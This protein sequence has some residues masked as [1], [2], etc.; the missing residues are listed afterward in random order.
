MASLRAGVNAIATRWSSIASGV[1]PGSF[2]RQTAAPHEHRV[3]GTSL[4]PSASALEFR[5]AGSMHIRSN[6]AAP[7]GS[8]QF[9][10]T[11]KRR[12]I[13]IWPIAVQALSCVYVAPCWTA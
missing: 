2:P 12:L 3:I 11:E 1:V 7:E 8:N 4:S 13:L 6:V 9:R 5:A 10:F